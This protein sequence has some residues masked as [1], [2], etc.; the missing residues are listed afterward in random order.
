MIGARYSQLKKLPRDPCTDSDDVR[1]IRK[2]EEQFRKNS[3]GKLVRRLAK[4]QPEEDPKLVYIKN[5]RDKEI[6]EEEKASSYRQ[7]RDSLED[8]R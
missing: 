5:Y 4:D 8:F 6:I 2:M 1:S 7:Q 3:E